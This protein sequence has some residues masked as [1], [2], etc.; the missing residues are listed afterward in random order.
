MSET[1]IQ[2]FAGSTAPILFGDSAA[3][4]IRELIAEEG[5]PNLKLRI[6]V[7]GGGCAGFQY[8]FAFDQTVN[9]DDVMVEKH[10]VRVLVDAM[11]FQYLAGAEIGYEDGLEGARFVIRN[12]N[13]VSTCGCGSSFSV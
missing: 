10:G 3:L 9:D 1:A 7:S 2:S 12:P 6:F 8:G 4:K 5:N 13:A 11:S